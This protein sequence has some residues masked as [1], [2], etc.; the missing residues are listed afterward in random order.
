MRFTSRFEAPRR[1]WHGRRSHLFA[2]AGHRS[3]VFCRHLGESNLSIL[4]RRQV[5]L[6]GFSFSQNEFGCVRQ[7]HG[8]YLEP[9][10]QVYK[11]SGFLPLEKLSMCN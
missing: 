10:Q 8:T 5:T 11:R 9:L 7:R 4:L 3:C 2:K 1:H 6:L